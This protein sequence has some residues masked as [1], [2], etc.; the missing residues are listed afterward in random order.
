MS[1]LA[2]DDDDDLIAISALQHLLYCARQFALIH[3]EQQWSENR[4]TAEGRVLHERANQSGTSTRKGVRHARSMPLRS[5]CYGIAG[6]ADIVELHQVGNDSR[7]HPVEYKRG[8]PK[9]HRADQVQLCAQALCL[10][11]MFNCSITEGSLFY[12]ETK[13]R[14]AVFFDAE[15]RALTVKAIS[16]AKTILASRRTPVAIYEPRKCDHCSLHEICRPK[17]L[18]NPCSAAA[19][20]AEIVEE[21]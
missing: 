8:R 1:Q 15:L 11:E 21:A 3:L 6:V 4:F 5:R 14:E 2:A 16:D 20:L 19:W 12:G 7:P 18:T 13:R 10:E 9:R 17:S